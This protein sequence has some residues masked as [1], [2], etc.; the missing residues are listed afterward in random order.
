MDCHLSRLETGFDTLNAVASTFPADPKGS[1]AIGPICR[2]VNA[3]VGC[4]FCVSEDRTEFQAHAVW[5]DGSLIPVELAYSANEN[6]DL[7]ARLSREHEVQVVVAARG[8]QVLKMLHERLG[9]EVTEALLAPLF[10]DTA[11]NGALLC[12][13][14]GQAGAFTSEDTAIVRAMVRVASMASQNAGLRAENEALRQK[15]AEL[16]AQ[17]LQ[18]A[19]LAA[20]G[21]LAASI[22]HEINNPLQSVQSCI[23]LVNDGV[24]ADGPSRQYLDIAREELDRIA[25]IVQ[26][27]ADFYRPSQ[28]SQRPTDLNALLETVLV[29]MG[30][31]LQQG[32]VKVT[33]SFAPDLP[34]VALSADQMK[35]VFVNLTLNALEAMPDGGEL[36]VCTQTVRKPQTAFVEVTFKDSGAGIP[37]EVLSRIFDPFFSTKAKGT[38]LGLSISHDI[39]ERHAGSIRAESK[40]GSGSV[41][42]VRLPAPG[43]AAGPE[44]A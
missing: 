19:K 12:G 14:T 13:R 7:L 4:V 18:S 2:A 40:A 9:I 1:L 35:Q 41:F 11:V 32:R 6:P 3:Q 20:T 24:P 16:N 21:K 43:G 8:Q 15:V 29:L 33:K 44:P 30:K 37:P 27:M 23:Y 17:L 34:L 25:K 38:G 36:Q 10:G 28:D 22:A 31:R 42:T 26:R 5:R 39:V